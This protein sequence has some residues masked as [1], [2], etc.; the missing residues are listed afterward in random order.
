MS[1]L[2]SIADDVINFENAYILTIQDKKNEVLD[3]I[4][5]EILDAFEN[6]K[7][8]IGIQTGYQKLDQKI[9]GLQ[10]GDL[11]I[12]G[13]RP[14]M[15]KTAFAL[16]IAVNLLRQNKNVYIFSYEMSVKELYYRMLGILNNTSINNLKRGL[17]HGA[18]FDEIESNINFIKKSNITILD[19]PT[20]N[21]VK[22]ECFLRKELLEKKTIDLVIIDYIQIMPGQK[23][24]DIYLTI[25][26]YSRKLKLLAKEIKTPVL[27]LSQLN[28]SVENRTDMKPRLSDLKNSGSLEQDADIVLFLSSKDDFWSYSIKKV[29]I[30]KHRHGQTGEVDIFFYPHKTLFLENEI[31]GNK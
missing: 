11:I 12:L 15:G 13:A 27:V 29:T 28:R 3:E 16:N 7:D 26:E 8:I 4:K 9:Q 5:Q 6:K 24:T 31:R 25:S 23:N 22:I 10:K 18:I 1:F 14:S 21:L 2:K 19:D 17:I 20:N 30:A